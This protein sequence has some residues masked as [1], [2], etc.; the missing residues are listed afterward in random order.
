M[1]MMMMMIIII[2]IIILDF[3]F[4]P[5]LMHEA[6]HSHPFSAEVKNAWSCTSIPLYILM[7]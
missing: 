1:M 7:A 2:I 5:K 4:Q 3:L 6:D